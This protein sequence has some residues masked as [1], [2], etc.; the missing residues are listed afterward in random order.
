MA[1]RP[2]SQMKVAHLPAPPLFRV[3]RGLQAVRRPGIF[4]SLNELE[5]RDV[6]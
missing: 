1:G 4:R 3:D 2:P 5:D 6:G